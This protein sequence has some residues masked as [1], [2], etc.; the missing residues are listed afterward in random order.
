MYLGN[1]KAYHTFDDMA[2][3]EFVTISLYSNNRM[4]QIKFEENFYSYCVLL[5]LFIVFNYC[6]KSVKEHF[7]YL[8]K[9][10]FN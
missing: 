10:V 2:L 8:R 1:R 4:L 3:S 5:L 7:I 9:K 6:I